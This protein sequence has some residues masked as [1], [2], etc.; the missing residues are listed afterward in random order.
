MSETT[1]FKEKF[2]EKLLEVLS[3][4][5]EERKV[6]YANNKLDDIPKDVESIIKKVSNKNGVISG[7]SGLIPGAFGMIIALPELTLLVKN[8]INMIYDIGR[9]LGKEKQITKE[10]ILGILLSSTGTTSLGILTVQGSKVVVK[11]TSLIVLKKMVGLHLS[12]LKK[13]LHYLGVK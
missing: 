11:G 10:L 3:N 6:D 12:Y 9:S 2:N 4:T 8:Q 13:W 1:N 7:A 5:I